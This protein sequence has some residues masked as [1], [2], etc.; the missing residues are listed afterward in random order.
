MV[1]NEAR[2]KIGFLRSDHGREF[3]SMEFNDFMRLMES[4][5]KSLLPSHP[6]KTE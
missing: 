6:N 3:T 4:R 5:D 2:M 1:E